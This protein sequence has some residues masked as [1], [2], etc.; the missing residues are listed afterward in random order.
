MLVTR[1]NTKQKQPII[2]TRMT[3]SQGIV[4]RIG[5]NTFTIGGAMEND[6]LKGSHIGNLSVSYARSFDPEHFSTIVFKHSLYY[7]RLIPSFHIK[8]QTLLRPEYV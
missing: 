4:N 7:P 3:C 1:L 8:G 6:A 2:A 5:L